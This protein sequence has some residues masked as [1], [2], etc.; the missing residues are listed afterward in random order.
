MQK[1]PVAIY[2]HIPFCKQKCLYCDFLSFCMDKT[3]HDSYVNNLLK[4]IEH[5]KNE[6]ILI[7][8]IF[9]GGGTPTLIEYELIGKILCKLKSCFEIASDAEI[10]IEANPGTVSFNSLS[11]YKNMGI[12]RISFGLQS[13]DDEELKRLGRIHDYKTFEESFFLARKA[14]FDNINVDLIMAIP[15]QHIAS[16][17]QTLDTVIA[18]APE[19]ISAYSLIIEEGTPYYDMYKDEDAACVGHDE[20]KEKYFS[21]PDEDEERSMYALNR[22]KLSA[23]GY[24]QYEISNFA[25]KGYES[26]H[27]IAYWTLKEYIGM[28]LGAS[29]YYKG[30]R[31]RNETDFSLYADHFI[32]EESRIKVSEK[33]TMEEMMFLGLRMNK[34]VSKKAFYRRFN[35]TVDEVFVGIKDKHIQ[36]GLLVEE[37]DYIRFTEKGMDLSNYCM[38]DFIID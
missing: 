15:G 27:N 20:K 34:G 10:T 16:Y 8:S 37:G 36:N 4:E 6:E 32:C 38:A 17:E 28:G 12:N 25:K 19:H 35:K 29:S 11:A 24:S 1:T 2:V 31:Y 22:C 26:R 7:D 9:F 18:L 30:E 33:D 23:A 5:Y 13:A 3:V 14:G 21:L